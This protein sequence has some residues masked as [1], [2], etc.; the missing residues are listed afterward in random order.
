MA[1]LHLS[2][3]IETMRREGYE[4][5]AG[6]PEVVYKEIDGVKCEPVEELTI[7]VDS[8]FVGAVSQELGIRKAELKT[9]ELTLTGSTR[10]TYEITTAALIGLRTILFTATKGYGNHVQYPQ[11][12]SSNAST[13][14]S[15][16]SCSKLRRSICAFANAN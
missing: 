7:E 4:L 2:V 8:E 3:L 5:E 11:G 13:F 16:T 6:R 1:K 14:S 9:Q 15:T 12:R 10:F